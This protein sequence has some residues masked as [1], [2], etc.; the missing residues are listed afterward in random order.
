MDKRGQ[1][2]L[3]FDQ[4]AYQERRW[5]EERR[6]RCD[7]QGSHN[8]QRPR[9]KGRKLTTEKANF[10][11]GMLGLAFSGGGIR[12]ATFNL[13]IL[14]A[15][16][17]LRMLRYVDVLSTVSGGGYIGAWFSGLLAR[18]HKEQSDAS[19]GRSYGIRQLEVQLDQ[20]IQDGNRTGPLHHLREYSNYLTPKHGLFSIDTWTIIAIYLRNLLLNWLVLLPFFSLILLMPLIL[21]ANPGGHFEPWLIGMGLLALAWFCLHGAIIM[22]RQFALVETR[23]Q[24]AAPVQQARPGSGPR[25][26]GLLLVFYLVATSH[27]VSQLVYLLP[28]EWGQQL[29][30]WLPLDNLPVW[31]RPA[32][33]MVATAVA[34]GGYWLLVLLVWRRCSAHCSGSRPTWRWPV[35]A[36]LV[37]CLT[38]Y[39]LIQIFEWLSQY[40]FAL[41]RMMLGPPV[42][43]LFMF[44]LG[45]LHM[46]LMDHRLAEDHREWLSRLGGWLLLSSVLWLLVFGL[47]FI[48][49]LL[50]RYL[51]APQNLALLLSWLGAIAAALLLRNANS[52]NRWISIGKRL[53]VAATPYLLIVGIIMMLSNSLLHGLT[54]SA[55]WLDHWLGTPVAQ[56]AAQQAAELEKSIAIPAEPISSLFNPTIREY[57]VLLEKVKGALNLALWAALLVIIGYT[58]SWLIDINR[59]S[60]QMFYQ[61][62]LVRAYLG[63]STPKAERRRG[64]VSFT[65]LNASDDLAMDRLRHHDGPYHIVNTAL[66]LAATDQLAWQ[67]RK[68]A[69]FVFTPLVYGYELPYL[70]TDVNGQSRRSV[71]YRPMA[72]FNQEPQY[73]KLT[74]GNAIATSGAAVSSNM[75]FHTTAV[76]SFLLT[77]FNVR[78]GRWL[79][80]PASSKAW[81]SA[82]PGSSHLELFREL[83]S[84]TDSDKPYVYLSDG[85]HFEN[86]GV[87]ELIRRRCRFII[88]CDAGADPDYDFDDLSNLIRKVRVDFGVEIHLDTTHIIPD[89]NGR[90]RHHCAVG[91][92]R[93]PLGKGETGIGTLLYIKASLCGEEPEDIRQF[94]K[95]HPDFPHQ[96][97]ADQFFSE[98]QFESYRRLG[99]YI[100]QQVLGQSVA[101][102]RQVMDDFGAAAAPRSTSHYDSHLSIERL[103][104]LMRS[105]WYPP[106]PAISQHFTR[107][108]QRYH[109]LM[110]ELRQ[111]PELGFLMWQFYPEWHRSRTDQR[112][113]HFCERDEVASID[114]IPR[115][116]EA[117]FRSAFTY[118]NQLIQLME[119]IYIDLQL[120]QHHAHPDN[121]GWM[122]LFRHWSWSGMFRLTW[123]IAASVYGRRFQ[124]FCCRRLNLNVGEVQAVM[125]KPDEFTA[126]LGSAS[127]FNFYEREQLRLILA[128]PKCAH[129]RVYTL[130]LGIED[131]AGGDL[132]NYIYGYAV[133][134]NDRVIAFRVQD[135]LR[136]M[137]LAQRGLRKLLKLEYT[138]RPASIH[139]KFSGLI[140]LSPD[141]EPW[142]DELFDQ[143][144]ERFDYTPHGRRRFRQVLRSTCWEVERTL[145]EQGG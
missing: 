120:D 83:L 19:H 20:E 73:N 92:I 12:S 109:T 46:A 38:G 25:A 8:R 74:L 94:A 106:S 48:G 91:E 113:R 124:L 86:L 53:L 135:H 15:L 105:Q 114:Y 7:Q 28:A 111:H 95:R 141:A 119:D 138:V 78:L 98:S 52:A 1:E 27:L 93:Y 75:G 125:H 64:T 88:A 35:T 41:A 67:E 136:R 96:T 61:N 62:R 87:Y 137:G 79:G 13:G 133:V 143:L 26:S 123:S 126:L 34:F 82:S 128:Q 21:T 72:S 23:R 60:M 139:T 58:V 9:R 108:S 29:V 11:K 140:D 71:A 145:R 90:S 49:P 18:R 129:A 50:I 85:G 54:W 103:F 10:E 131:N 115:D 81:R 107:H 142:Q 134:V 104:S 89:E 55:D 22:G 51:S 99:L 116:N 144:C 97:T 31:V 127:E 118:C 69:S 43:L 57:F 40:E 59:Y 24:S 42:L 44:G 56:S 36:V 110:E 6:R 132:M 112:Y 45:V 3:N 130:R 32:L 122:N 33:A 66:N 39:P 68:A 37:G 16:A 2:P 76:F 4:V 30:H 102:A 47:M 117:V 17:S 121:R 101:D 65:G 70:R 84:G 77:F 63:A 5:I 14:Q 80:N 100:G